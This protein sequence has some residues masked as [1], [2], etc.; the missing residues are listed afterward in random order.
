MLLLLLWLVGVRVGVGVGVGIGVVVVVV[1][2]IFVVIVL[3]VVVLVPFTSPWKVV[4]DST[5]EITPNM[6][7]RVFHHLPWGGE[8]NNSLSQS[9]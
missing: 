8:G 4:K 5:N 9:N 2:F 1:V 3:V 6:I 7:G